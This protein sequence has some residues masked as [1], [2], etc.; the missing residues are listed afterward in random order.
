LFAVGSL[1][2][3]HTLVDVGYDGDV[4]RNG[5]SVVQY[6]KRGVMFACSHTRMQVAI[7][8]RETLLCYDGKTADGLGS[9]IGHT[10]EDLFWIDIRNKREVKVHN[11]IYKKEKLVV[12]KKMNKKD[13]VSLGDSGKNFLA[14]NV[15]S[16]GNNGDVDEGRCDD[17]D[18]YEDSCVDE[19]DVYEDSC[20]DDGDDIDYNDIN[21]FANDG[22][23]N[24]EKEN[25]QAAKSGIFHISYA[26]ALT[27][28]VGLTP[29]TF[30]VF[31]SFFGRTKKVAR[32]SSHN[33]FVTLLK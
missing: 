4:V 23:G 15:A 29:A 24:N 30:Q 33:V 2:E 25:E 18:V 5:I 11:L 3:T 13:D 14:G 6:G 12:V 16:E 7:A 19:D 27:D 28:R 22:F 21:A 8:Q 31:L 20:D 26:K 1:D 17:D 9:H 10:A 32:Q